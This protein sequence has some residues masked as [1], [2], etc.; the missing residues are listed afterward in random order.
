MSSE[1]CKLVPLSVERARPQLSKYPRNATWKTNNDLLKD[2]LCNKIMQVTLILLRPHAVPHN[3]H[4][5]ITTRYTPRR[6][7][8]Q[9]FYPIWRRK[10]SAQSV[11][12]RI[13]NWCVVYFL[14]GTCKGQVFPFCEVYFHFWIH[15]TAEL[16]KTFL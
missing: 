12:R 1:I 6:T 3:T 9:L 5:N 14:L 15:L 4:K 10:V 7:L 8:H 13:V 2:V 16:Q 11:R